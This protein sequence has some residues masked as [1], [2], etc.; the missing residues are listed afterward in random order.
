[1]T[2]L[3]SLLGAALAL[4]SMGV[5]FWLLDTF[6]FILFGL[7]LVVLGIYLLA[8]AIRKIVQGRARANR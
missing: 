4:L 6:P 1:M 5:M 2:T 3:W 7:V 8:G